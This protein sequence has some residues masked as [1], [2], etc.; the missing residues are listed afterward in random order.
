MQSR[1]FGALP[2]LVENDNGFQIIIRGR[3]T[4]LAPP[5]L[6]CCATL[7]PIK[8]ETL[9]KELNVSYQRRAQNTV[10]GMEIRIST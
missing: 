10:N 5:L 2:T 1:D 8:K 4:L 7:D 3:F 6:M 9:L